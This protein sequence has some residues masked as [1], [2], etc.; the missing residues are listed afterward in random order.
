[1]LYIIGMFSSVASEP[2]RR[3]GWRAPTSSAA[4]IFHNGT[5]WCAQL[6]A[7]K[8]TFRDRGNSHRSLEL[9]VAVKRLS[10][11][12]V[13]RLLQPVLLFPQLFYDVGSLC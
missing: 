13:L 11:L 2:A 4:C 1:M 8:R 10:L 6:S 9:A 12:I 3:T 7:L 5:G